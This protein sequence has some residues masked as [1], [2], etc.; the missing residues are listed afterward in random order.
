MKITISFVH[1]L[2]DDGVFVKLSF[3]MIIDVP[4]MNSLKEMKKG[5]SY[6]VQWS[7]CNAC[8]PRALLRHE[9]SPKAWQFNSNNYYTFNHVELLSVYLFI[10]Y[11]KLYK[12]T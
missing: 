1:L 10:S 6:I 7:T 3:L 2:S 9:T 4:F 5:S 12:V 11:I 8:T